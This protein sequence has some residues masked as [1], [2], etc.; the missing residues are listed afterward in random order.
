[1][2]RFELVLPTARKYLRQQGHDVTVLDRQA[3]PAAETSHANGGQISVSQ[4]SSAW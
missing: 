1:M 2:A 4:C 3:K